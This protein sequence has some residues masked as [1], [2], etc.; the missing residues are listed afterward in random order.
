MAFVMTLACKKPICRDFG[1]TSIYLGGFTVFLARVLGV[2]PNKM[3]FVE[4]K[5][6]LALS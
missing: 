5:A 3:R 2:A 6:Y 1:I 4:Q